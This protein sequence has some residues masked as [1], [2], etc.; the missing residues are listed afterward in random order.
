MID[1][2]SDIDKTE[3]C[4]V[5]CSMNWSTLA[6]VVIGRPAYDNYLVAMAIRHGV[7][8]VDATNTVLAVHISEQG[9]KSR[10]NLN[11]DAKFN[12]KI[13]GTFNYFD[14]Y[15]SAAGLN[16]VDDFLGNVVI[17]KRRKRNYKPKKI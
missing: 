4:L 8:V 5:G 13:I 1:Q 10:L 6:D 9:A 11:N 7:N 15:T 17:V 3:L 2:G 16:T 14:G 12:E